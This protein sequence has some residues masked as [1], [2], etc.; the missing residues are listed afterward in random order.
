VPESTLDEFQLALYRSGAE[1]CSTA[2][3]CNAAQ[4]DAKLA[5]R[6]A[7]A[8][9][10]IAAAAARPVPPPGPRVQTFYMYRAQSEAS[11]PLE[12]I[13]TA[14]LA[15]VFWYLHQE[16]VGSTPRK[17]SIDRIKRFKVSVKNTWEFWNAHKRQFS[18]FVAYDA[19]GC[20]SPLCRDIYH[21]YG[22]VVGCQVQPLAVAGYLG[23]H[24]TNW[25][26][27]PGEDTCRA[28]VWYSL[29][30]PCPEK[31]IP[32]REIDADST[33]ID[34]D[35]YKTPECSQRMPGGLCRAGGVP[36]GA[37]DCTYSYEE[38]GEILLNELVGIADYSDFWDKSYRDCIKDKKSG[39]LPPETACVHQKE[40]D[41]HTDR[42]VGTDFWDG[43]HDRGRC[44]ARLEKARQLFRQKFPQFPE[45]EEP[46]CEFDMYYSD[47]FEWKINHTHAPSSSWWQ[48]RA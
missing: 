38:A 29:P 26:C 21:Q 18:A 27:S 32:N 13:N 17:Y 25:Q 35:R 23:K 14:D 31:G 10:A 46:P 39:A 36:T 12:N 19:G 40:Y 37:P 7:A 28:P 4:L 8:A 22:F 33:H 2:P 42:G 6:K 1:N 20:T 41:S 30:G 3:P 5:A 44:A 48:Q 34:V 45:L 43:K 15:G 24:Q 9:A 16:V 47:E 11:Y